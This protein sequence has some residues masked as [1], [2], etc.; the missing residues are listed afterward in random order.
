MMIMKI[1]GISLTPQATCPPYFV[2]ASGSTT[3]SGRTMPYQSWAS[4]SDPIMMMAAKNPWM[5]TISRMSP[6]RAT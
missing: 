6:K 4:G 1:M 3:Q 5:P 2:S